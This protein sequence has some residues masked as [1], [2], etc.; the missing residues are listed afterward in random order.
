MHRLVNYFA[1]IV[2]VGASSG[3]SA[4]RFIKNKRNLPGSCPASFESSQ[5]VSHPPGDAQVHLEAWSLLSVEVQDVFL[6]A[7]SKLGALNTIDLGPKRSVT[8]GEL[9]LWVQMTGP[10]FAAQVSA[11]VSLGEAPTSYGKAAM[12]AK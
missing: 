10:R 6:D 8:V 1:P 12:V 4:R 3:T 2:C 11:A 9:V 5:L 7:E